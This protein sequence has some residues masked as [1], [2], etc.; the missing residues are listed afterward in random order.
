LQQPL[1]VSALYYLQYGYYHEVD[2]PDE[3]VLL[4]VDPIQPFLKTIS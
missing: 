2:A 4:G 3:G 1:Q